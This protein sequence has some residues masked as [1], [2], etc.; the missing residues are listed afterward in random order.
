[1]I[2]YPE[3]YI[4]LQCKRIYG[5]CLNELQFLNMNCWDIFL[6]RPEPC[7]GNCRS[8]MMGTWEVSKDLQGS[9]WRDEKKKRWIRRRGNW[10]KYKNT[11]DGVNFRG[12]GCN[13]PLMHPKKI[14]IFW[15]YDVLILLVWSSRP[16]PHQK[17]NNKKINIVEDPS[18][19]LRIWSQLNNGKIKPMKAKG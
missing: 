9:E 4:L 12:G 16:R 10:S 3:N 1:M 15:M 17:K 7:V 13:V 2:G 5:I 11:E 6:A 19:R 18:C 14:R 8:W